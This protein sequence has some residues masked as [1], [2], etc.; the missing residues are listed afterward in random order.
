MKYRKWV[1]I[2][3]ILYMSLFL[4]SCSDK[5]DIKVNK[6][7]ELQGEIKLWSDTDSLKA[8]Q[9]SA[10]S[11]M[12]SHSKVKITIENLESNQNIIDKISKNTELTLSRPDAVVIDDESIPALVESNPDDF[13]D[14][15]KIVSDEKSKFTT[16][17]IYGVTYKDKI[18]AYPWYDYPVGI[19]YRTDIIAKFGFNID[20]IRTWNDFIK[21]GEEINKDSSGKVKII[22]LNSNST[23]LFKLMMNQLD[24][25]DRDKNDISILNGEKPIRTMS[26]IKRFKSSGIIKEVNSSDEIYSSLNDGSTAC[27]ILP[28]QSLSKIKG[29]YPS[30]KGKL[31]MDRL[32]SFEVGGNRAASFGGKS[33]M[34]FKN[35]QNEKVINDFL[36]YTVSD[37]ETVLNNLLKND[38]FTDFASAYRDKRFEVKNDFF[39]NQKILKTYA[40]INTDTYNIGFTC[41]FNELNKNILIAQKK[42]LNGDNFSTTMDELFTNSQ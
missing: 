12:K 20:D 41:D 5:S 8:L 32:P 15:T 27:M 7:A 23:E 35:T 22:S 18:R 33:I 42:I 6:P 14:L 34:V 38:T 1:W 26:L 25:T 17:S 3:T 28:I 10:D 40:Q 9:Y 2:L 31:Q 24:G 4:T 19:F 11:Y 13:N 36:N 29:E 16:G 21:A 39:N 37:K 30:L